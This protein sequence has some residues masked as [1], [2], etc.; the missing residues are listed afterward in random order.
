MSANK[1]GTK[2]ANPAVAVEQ[3]DNSLFVPTFVETKTN[4]CNDCFVRTIDKRKQSARRRFN[5]ESET[6]AV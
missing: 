3:G 1:V 2:K 6:Y 4:A 5:E